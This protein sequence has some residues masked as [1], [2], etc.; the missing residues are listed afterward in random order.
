MDMGQKNPDGTPAVQEFL[1]LEYA[2]SAV[3]YVPVS[4]LQLISRLHG[5][6][7]DARCTTGGTAV[8]KASAEASEQ[9]V[10]RLR[11]RAAEHLCAPRRTPGP[12]LPLLA[13]GLRAVRQRLRLRG[14][15]GP[16]RRHPRRDPGHDQPPAHG[17]PSLRRR[18]LRQD[19]SRPARGLRG[20][21]GRQAGGLSRAHHAAGRAALPDPGG[22]LLQ[23]ADQ[24]GR[25]LALSLGQGDHGGRQGHCRRL[26]G[27][28][29]G[30][31]QAAVG[32]HAVQEPGPAD[33]RRGA[34]LR[35]APQG[36]HEGHARRGGRAHPDGHAHPAHHGHGA[37]RPARPVRHRHRAPAAPGH[38]D[39]CAQRGHGRHPRGR[40]ARAQARRPVLLPAQRGRDH[41]E[42]QAKAGGNPA[43]GTHRRGP[44]PDARARARTRHARLRGPALQHPAVLDHHRDRHR[45]AQRQHH[46]H[47]PR[48]QV[49]PG[50]VAPTARP[51]GPQPPPGLCL[52]DGAR[53]GQPDQAGPAAAGSHPAD[54]GTGLG[55]LPG[56]ARPGDPRRRRGAGR[57]PERQHD[58]GGL[59][60][61]QRDAVRGRAQPQGRQGARPAQPAVGLHRHQP[62]RAGPAAQ[63]LLRRRAPAPVLLQEA[64]HGTH[65]RPDRHPARRNRGPLRQA[66]AP[67]PDPDR[68]A[69]PARAVP[70][71]WRG[72]GRCRARR[73]HHHLQAP[74]A[75]G[76]DG[77]HPPDP[78]E[79]AHQAG[80]Q[81]KA[82]HRARAGHARRPRPDGARRA[83][84]PGPAL[85][86]LLEAS[87]ALLA[88]ATA[89]WLRPWR[90]AAGR[91]RPGGPQDRIACAPDHSPLLAVL[92]LLPWIWA[93]PTL[94]R[95][96]W[97]IA[98]VIAPL[99]VSC[100]ELPL[101]V[102]CS[103]RGRLG[104]P[105][106]SPRPWAGRCAGHRVC[107]ASCPPRW[108]MLCGAGCRTRSSSSSWCAAS[109]AR[110]CA[111]SSPGCWARRRAMPCRASMKTCRASRAGSWPG[112][113]PWSP[114]WPRPSSWSFGPGGWP[115]GPMPSTCPAR[116]RP[117]G[118]QEHGTPER[119]PAGHWL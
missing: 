26:G 56:H 117:D 112:A 27:H 49:R 32:V 23:V 115:P 108:T 33:H 41:R 61:L 68:R 63:R 113:T 8:G 31:A 91:P 18:G 28:R 97:A 6:A 82:A 84:Q 29:R 106:L 73:H 13:P 94:H 114:A 110:C 98:V 42:P 37:R 3:L 78:E 111:S 47:Q 81:R 80:R 16:A 36:S 17:P 70:A 15:G 83:A 101:S 14:N 119:A 67:G 79:Q 87:I 77:H 116:P 5:V 66:A 19:R 96:R 54:G 4:Q 51:R 69:P 60:A 24:G 74:A 86:M 71:L 59:S 11:R 25:S 95:M 89:L 38:Q 103:L 20:D 55:L 34:P 88:L 45:R 93:L 30:H 105:L 104:R 50:P 53:P 40:A 12:C 90:I 58:G 52:P 72:Q 107:K 65:Q 75:R 1:H 21:Y 57:E 76:P 7:R 39:L 118:G 62:A 43:R 10:A 48:R 64:G 85:P 44:R 35:R 22:P 92:V 109:R 102:R 46:P 2:G 9:L 100:C 99:V